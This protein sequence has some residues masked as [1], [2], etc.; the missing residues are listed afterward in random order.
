M[1]LMG[2]DITPAKVISLVG[3][4]L[5]ARGLS[6]SP[7]D[8]VLAAEGVEPSVEPYSFNLHALEENADTT[9]AM[10]L[11]THRGGLSGRAVVLAKRIFRAAGQIFINE[12][13]S[14]QRVFNGH[15]RDSYAQLSAEV[16]RLRTRI[17]ELEK[18]Q[19]RGA[20]VEVELTQ[21]PVEPD[22][23]ATPELT[24]KP[25]KAPRRVTKPNV[26][27]PMPSAA[28]ARPTRPSRGK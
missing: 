26:K 8:S 12:A 20:E 9:R 7:V 19:S 22:A 11:E 28:A 4:R 13:L 6:S 21:A 24:A 23:V 14:R 15:V 17:A 5:A 1:N 3:A 18:V 25:P 2:K 16:L 10:P 27:S